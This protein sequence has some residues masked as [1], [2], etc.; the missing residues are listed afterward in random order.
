MNKKILRCFHSWKAERDSAERS[1]DKS[2]MSWSLVD[3]RGLN[4]IPHELCLF[5]GSYTDMFY[6]HLKIYL[7]VW[8]GIG[9]ASEYLP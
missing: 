6:D 9:C 1:Q 3:P 8:S 2:Y 4:G 7:F 5:P